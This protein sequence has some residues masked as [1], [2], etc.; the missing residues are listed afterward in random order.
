MPRPPP[1]TSAILSSSLPVALSVRRRTGGLTGDVLAGV[2]QHGHHVV[3]DLA[4]S[5]RDPNP[6]HGATALAVGQHARLERRDQRGMVGQHADLAVRSRGAHFAHVL[7]DELTLAGVDAQAQHL[8][9]PGARALLARCARCAAPMPPDPALPCPRA[10]F[11]RRAASLAWPH[12]A[13]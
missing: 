5:A 4:E 12:A 8:T 3:A 9:P 6:R 13:I 1:V 2:G 11:A 10:R 7:V